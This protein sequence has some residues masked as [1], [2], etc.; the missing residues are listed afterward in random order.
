MSHAPIKLSAYGVWLFSKWGKLEVRQHTK[1][2]FWPLTGKNYCK[3]SRSHGICL[4]AHLHGMCT[5]T[6]F[7]GCPAPFAC[8]SNV[9]GCPTSSYRSQKCF[10]QPPSQL[11]WSMWESSDNIY[12]GESHWHKWE[13]WKSRCH[14]T[15][16]QGGWP[17][18][19]QC[20][21]GCGHCNWLHSPYSG[22]SGP[23]RDV[24]DFLTASQT[25]HFIKLV[26]VKSIL[27]MPNWDKPLT[28][29]TNKDWAKI[30]VQMTPPT[31]SIQLWP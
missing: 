6:E 24:A 5:L 18:D 19:N 2:L 23:P 8:L 28:W 9:Q 30:K 10:L 3:K 25:L 4:V 26:R 17:R 29:S 16:L 11:G 1:G 12:T 7:F 27:V 21:G 22:S 13:M 15:L 14:W 20:L 31:F